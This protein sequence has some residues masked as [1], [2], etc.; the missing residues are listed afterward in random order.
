MAATI[1]GL[2]GSAFFKLREIGPVLLGNRVWGLHSFIGWLVL[3]LFLYAVPRCVYLLFF[4]P[5][6]KFPGPRLAAVSNIYYA[7]LW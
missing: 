1:E 4:H 7:A 2:E 5:L 6:A 3:L